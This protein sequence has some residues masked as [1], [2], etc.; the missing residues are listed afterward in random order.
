[1]DAAGIELFVYMSLGLFKI[2]LL[3]IFVP[4]SL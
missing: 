4:Q 1:M 2:G 3:R